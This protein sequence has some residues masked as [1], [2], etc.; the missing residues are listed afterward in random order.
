MR[1][2]ATLAAVVAAMALSGIAALAADPEVYP[3]YASEDNV[4]YRHQPPPP[5]ALRAPPP[6]APLIPP[7]PPPTAPPPAARTTPSPK[8]RTMPPVRPAP[9]VDA[10]TAADLE[11]ALDA[12]RRGDYAEALD[13]IRPLAEQ[14]DATAQSRLAGLY[15]HGAGVEQDVVEAARWYRK[16]AG[17]GDPSAG[18]NLGSML[19]EGR[20][21]AREGGEAGL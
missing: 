11:R 17:G 14:G 21:G 5:G 8:T 2:T 4:D 20:G 10:A 7:S 6:P 18:H 15:E 12:Y 1:I 19:S 9:P 16:A 13:I 3:W